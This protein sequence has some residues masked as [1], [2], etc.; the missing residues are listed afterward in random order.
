M[1]SFW[2]TPETEAFKPSRRYVLVRLE[3]SSTY[4]FDAIYNTVFDRILEVKTIFQ[5]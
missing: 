4:L 5:G 1:G 3:P 2:D